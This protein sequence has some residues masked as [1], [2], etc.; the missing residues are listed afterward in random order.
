[1]CG[2]A[3]FVVWDGSD[4]AESRRALCAM[5]RTIR[6][7]GPDDEGVWHSQDGVVGLG[8]RRLAILDLSPTGHQPMLSKTGRFAIVFNGEV[9]N[10]MELRDDLRGRGHE[11]H[12]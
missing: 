4:P 9:Y 10:H 2:F 12:G 1:M 7:R 5:V 8:F 3:G 11:F 6:H